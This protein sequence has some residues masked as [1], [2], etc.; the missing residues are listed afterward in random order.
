MH[1]AFTRRPR[2]ASIAT[3]RV[4]QSSRVKFSM[5]VSWNRHPMVIQKTAQS[6]HPEFSSAAQCLRWSCPGRAFLQGHIQRGTAGCRSIVQRQV[7][8]KNGKVIARTRHHRS[9]TQRASAETVNPLLVISAWRQLRRNTAVEVAIDLV[10]ICVVG[11]LGMT[12]PSGHT[13]LSLF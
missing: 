9:L 11:V 2:S 3:K 10:I 7:N 12:M 4:K 13:H 1:L 6:R 8:R 5:R